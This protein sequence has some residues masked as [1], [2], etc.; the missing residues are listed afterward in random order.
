MARM[1]VDSGDFVEAYDYIKRAINE[2]GCDDKDSDQ[3][4]CYSTLATICTELMGI[5][6]GTTYYTEAV[7]AFEKVI[8][9]REKNLGK[10]HADTAVAYHDYAYFW[11]VCGVYDKALIYNEMANTI[12]KELFSEH[13]ITR[14]RN[15]NTKALIIWEQGDIKQANDIF[16]YIIAESEKMSDDYL[17]D[18]AQFEF[19]Y[20]RCLHYQG[21]DDRAKEYYGKCIAIWT[22]MSNAGNRNHA[23]AHQERADILFSEGNAPDA[24]KDYEKAKKY[25]TEDFYVFVDIMDSMA[26]CLILC[27]RVDEGI[28]MFKELLK[29]LVEYN[30]T[31]AETKYQLCNN[32]F[33][34]LDA[35]S[36]E[37]VEWKKKL[38]EQIEGNA[39]IIEYVDNYLPNEQEK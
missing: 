10:H 30:A 15:L 32:L 20:A 4:I 17:I 2:G 14:M 1:L 25:I 29:F 28:S 11:Y 22:Q 31:D 12:E 13:S 9:F 36:D 21:N 37:E 38:M 5:G 35:A 26:A 27:H 33:C 18:V 19:N 34:I 16:D 6:D 39:D 7:N 23:L 3:I 8:Q 24:L